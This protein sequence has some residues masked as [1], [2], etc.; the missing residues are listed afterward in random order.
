MTQHAQNHRWIDFPDR[1]VGT[2]Q[3]LRAK[4]A[5]SGLRDADAVA[6]LA[7]IDRNTDRTRSRQPA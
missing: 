4:L 6:A 3:L 2:R 5:G 1:R 7:T